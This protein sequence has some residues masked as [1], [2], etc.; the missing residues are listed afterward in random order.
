MVFNSKS[1][2]L[3]SLGLYLLLTLK[4]KLLISRTTGSNTNMVPFTNLWLLVSLSVAEIIYSF[5]NI[6]VEIFFF[7]EVDDNVVVRI[8]T[9][10]LF[11][12]AGMALATVWSITINRLLSTSHPLW[13][14]R[15]VTKNKFICLFMCM[16]IVIVALHIT[17]AEMRLGGLYR[18]GV[19]R[20]L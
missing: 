10:C 6:L 18:D 8:A 15:S 4:R 2:L 17:G 1:I 7:F 13:Y 5:M 16:W 14:R 9:L 11:A 19:N 12:S 20:K 3:H